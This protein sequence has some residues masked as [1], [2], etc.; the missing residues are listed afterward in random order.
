LKKANGYGPPILSGQ[1]I[2]KVTYTGFPQ[3]I[4]ILIIVMLETRYLINIFT[5][6]L[7]I[8]DVTIY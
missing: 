6:R 4:H 3:I 7:N 8:Q 1:V 5:T 2:S